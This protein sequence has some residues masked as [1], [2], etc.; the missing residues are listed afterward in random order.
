[1]SVKGY[2]GAQQVVPA[3]PKVGNTCVVSMHVV[4]DSQLV[5]DLNDPD[6]CLLPE[7]EWPTKTPRSKVYASDHEWFLICKVGFERGMFVPITESEIF[8]TGSENW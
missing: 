5:A 3:W 4:V 6:N 7:C 8:V 2:L 1:M